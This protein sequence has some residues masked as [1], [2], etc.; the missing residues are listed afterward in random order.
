MSRFVISLCFQC[1]DVCDCAHNE[2]VLYWK[3]CKDISVLCYATRTSLR[4]SA[5]Y[6]LPVL[7]HVYLFVCVR[8]SMIMDEKSNVCV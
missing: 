5:P 7:L 8:M 2:C 4:F 1:S 6:A 3:G